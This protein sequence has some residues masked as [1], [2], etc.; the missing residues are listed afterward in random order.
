VKRLYED[1]PGLVPAS[2]LP[3]GDFAAAVASANGWAAKTRVVL[4]FLPRLRVAPLYA[5][6][7]FTCSLVLHYGLSEEARD[8]VILANST[9]VTNLEQHKYWTLI[10]SAFIVEEHIEIPALLLVLCV[11]SLAELLWGWRRLIVVFLAGHVLASCLVYGL[12]RAGVHNNAVPGRV[13]VAADVGV[14]YGVLGVSGAIAMTLPVRARR[15]LVPLALL[16]VVVPLLVRPTFT[17]LGHLLAILIGFL[18]GLSVRRRPL[19]G[20]LRWPAVLRRDTVRT[21]AFDTV[22]AA[23][24]GLMAALRSQ[25]H[26]AVRLEDATVAWRDQRSRVHVRQTRDLDALD[27]AL[28][29]AAWGL[30]VGTLVGVPIVGMVIGALVT[31]I[32]A[33]VHDSGLTDAVVEAA[34]QSAPPGS[35]VLLLLINESAAAAD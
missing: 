11:M 3:G 16:L 24:E 35:A 32:G 1:P 14:S 8:R 17:D 18:A 13:L 29:G 33:H 4:S 5:L 31:A 2:Y 25:E 30:V 7:V 27:G 22:A 28:A 10:T 19:A 12:L 21:Y 26:H 23:N 15:I 34:V 20:R 9:N 6:A